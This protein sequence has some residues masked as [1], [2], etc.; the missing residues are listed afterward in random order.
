MNKF[1]SY[2]L[3]DWRPITQGNVVALGTGL[4]PRTA[5]ATF[6]CDQLV[7]IFASYF[8]DMSD[9]VL[10]GYGVGQIDCSISANRDVFIRYEAE[11]PDARVWVKTKDRS[12]TILQRDEPTFT[13]IDRRAGQNPEIAAML[14]K[15]ELNAMTRESALRDEIDKLRS[16]A[17]EPTS[18][19]R[20]QPD[21]DQ[22][23]TQVDQTPTPAKPGKSKRVHREPDPEATPAQDPDTPS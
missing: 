15:I 16:K 23:D 14:R 1:T 19:Q 4:N 3:G 5:A 2:D 12:H 9:Q 20:R 13:T 17:N 6:R 7:R 11:F 22:A 18:G 8:E 10:I 21:Q